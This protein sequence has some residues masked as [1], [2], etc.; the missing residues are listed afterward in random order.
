M[1]ESPVI[2][3][4]SDTY[5][6]EFVPWT[7]NQV[8][9]FLFNLTSREWKSDVCRVTQAE[10]YSIFYHLLESPIGVNYLEELCS[11]LV[12]LPKIEIVPA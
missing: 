10:Y 12:L 8:L 3:K 9:N 11:Y 6:V 7:I 5:Q 1:K 2:L 4:L